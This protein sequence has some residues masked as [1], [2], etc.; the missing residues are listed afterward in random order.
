MPKNPAE[1]AVIIPPTHADIARRAAEIWENR[2]RPEGRDEEIWLE[3]ERQLLGMDMLAQS[4]KNP[5]SAR[6]KR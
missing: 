4:S 1:P 6:S 5:P 3:A 2:G